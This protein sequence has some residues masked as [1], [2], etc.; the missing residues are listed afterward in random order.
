M[1]LIILLKLKDCEIKENE[2]YSLFLNVFRI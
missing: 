2:N 1:F